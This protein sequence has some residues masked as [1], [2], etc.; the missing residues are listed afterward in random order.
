[1]KFGKKLG[2]MALSIMIHGTMT[3]IITTLSVTTLGIITLCIN[4]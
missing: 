4:A 1:M 3:F 2:M